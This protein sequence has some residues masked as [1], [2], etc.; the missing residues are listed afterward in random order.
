[1]LKV[2]LEVKT[3]DGFGS[4]GLC[5]STDGSQGCAVAR[6]KGAIPPAGDSLS[7][8][9]SRLEGSG[10]SSDDIV[11]PPWIVEARVGSVT[12]YEPPP[13]SHRWDSVFSVEELTAAAGGGGGG[14]EKRSSAW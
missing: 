12:W 10:P 14:G 9:L 4:P 5:C 6:W 1:M 3:D 2:G 8:R 11:T 7:R 13:C